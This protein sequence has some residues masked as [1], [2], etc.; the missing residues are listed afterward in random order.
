MTLK[1]L[2]KRLTKTLAHE[3]VAL[4]FCLLKRTSRAALPAAVGGSNEITDRMF[5]PS[6]IKY[7]CHQSCFTHLGFT[8]LELKCLHFRLVIG[9][10]WEVQLCRPPLVLPTPSA[11]VTRYLKTSSFRQE[12]YSNTTASARTPPSVLTHTCMHVHTQTGILLHFLKEG[13]NE[14]LIAITFALCLMK[15]RISVLQ[16]VENRSS[17]SMN[18]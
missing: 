7:R 2:L 6:Y 15:G 4:T 1:I 5:T 11:P 3:G 18:N 17:S 14:M 12:H 13:N 16:R 8:S 9:K 10:G